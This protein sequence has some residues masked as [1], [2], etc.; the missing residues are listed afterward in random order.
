M[1]L[2]KGITDTDYGAHP[3]VDQSKMLR[4]AFTQV[5]ESEN[6]NTAGLINDYGALA[7]E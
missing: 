2:N 5:I 1:L 4:E 6:D 7:G 3:I